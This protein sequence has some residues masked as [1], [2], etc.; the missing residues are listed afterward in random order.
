[1]SASKRFNN[2]NNLRIGAKLDSRED[3]A[4]NVQITIPLDRKKRSSRRHLELLAN[5]KDPAFQ[6]K[7][8]TGRQVKLG[9][10]ALR[11]RLRP[12]EMIKVS[13]PTLMLNIEIQSTKPV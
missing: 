7:R 1:L 4:M 10:K 13:I 9:A 12:Y 8:V 3:F 6:V 5:S 11:G 2:G